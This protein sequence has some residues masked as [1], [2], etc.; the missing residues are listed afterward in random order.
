M[1]SLGNCPPGCCLS[2]QCIVTR[3]WWENAC[4]EGDCFRVLAIFLI[5]N[6]SIKN[7]QFRKCQDDFDR[8][9]LN[10]TQYVHPALMSGHAYPRHISNQN[11]GNGGCGAF[12]ACIRAL[13]Q[14]SPQ[15][16]RARAKKLPEKALVV[17]TMNSTPPKYHPRILVF[18]FMT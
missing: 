15:F 7:W 14:Q 18:I 1:G 4:W 8:H 10:S 16:T 9:H 12:A 17:S 11:S 5:E 3:V 6:Q 2:N 13:Q